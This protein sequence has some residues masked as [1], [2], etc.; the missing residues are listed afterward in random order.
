MK[1]SVSTSKTVQ[2]YTH[3]HVHL[4]I[5]LHG[6]ANMPVNVSLCIRLGECMHA[7]VHIHVSA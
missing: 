3:V 5:C 7:C 2:M 1:S 4:Y 6:F